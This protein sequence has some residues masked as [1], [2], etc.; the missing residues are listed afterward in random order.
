MLE[1]KT[2]YSQG[3]CLRYAL[4]MSPRTAHSI[5]AGLVALCFSASL[6]AQ[7]FETL[8]MEGLTAY[9]EGDYEDA[10]E[11]FE[12]AYVLNP[13]PVLLYNIARSY[14]KQGNDACVSALDYYQHFID[15]PHPD[16]NQIEK[17]KLHLAELY[18]CGPLPAFHGVVS[19]LQGDPV[20]VVISDGCAP[21]EEDGWRCLGAGP[22]VF[23]LRNADGSRS[24]Q[25][26]EISEL[27]HV[28]RIHTHNDRLLLTWS[29]KKSQGEALLLMD[30][31]ALHLADRGAR[32]ERVQN[33]LGCSERL[34]CETPSLEVETLPTEFVRSCQVSSCG[35]DFVRSERMVLDRD[36]VR[37]VSHAAEDDHLPGPMWEGHDTQGHPL[38][39][40]LL[41]RCWSE[42]LAGQRQPITCLHLPLRIQVEL[43]NGDTPVHTLEPLSLWQDDLRGLD[44]LPVHLS[45][46][47]PFARAPELLELR[48]GQGNMAWLTA[49][50][51]GLHPVLTLEPE[52]GT[53]LE[54]GVEGCEQSLSCQLSPLGDVRWPELEV[55]CEAQ[56]CAGVQR[57]ERNLAWV[58]QRYER[59]FHVGDSDP[60]VMSATGEEVRVHLSSGLLGCL[61]SRPEDLCE[62]LWVELWPDGTQAVYEIPLE[63]GYALKTVEVAP[64]APGEPP[65]L[66]LLLE[67][68]EDDDVYHSLERSSRWYAPMRGE[69]PALWMEFRPE[70]RFSETVHGDLDLD[71]PLGS[72]VRGET[73]CTHEVLPHAKAL[74][75]G[76]VVERCRTVSQDNCEGTSGASTLERLYQST[77]EGYT[78]HPELQAV[79]LEAVDESILSPAVFELL[80]QHCKDHEIPD[81]MAATT[82]FTVSLD[83]RG[84]Q[85]RA[86]RIQIARELSLILLLNADGEVLFANA[87]HRFELLSTHHQG[88]FDIRGRINTMPECYQDTLFVWQKGGYNVGE[89]RSEVCR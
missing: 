57:W 75:W 20:G 25:S 84:T 41:S 87:Q 22:I 68:R 79:P 56:S 6:E 26:L 18:G 50:S 15:S 31:D 72:E 1:R 5:I 48:T 38:S 3:A 39:Y 9:Q 40:T 24:T 45:T 34:T 44:A 59:V 10:V 65:L 74:R 78:S 76:P 37:F 8:V 33:G 81:C 32:V 16:P 54:P 21:V 47:A 61:D 23:E 64:L 52:R 63:L 82:T 53:T 30:T 36:A 12:A 71:C 70:Y 66:H 46:S 7:D 62:P 55:R 19:D 13:D 88:Y 27:G 83:T 43:P 60:R 69:A 42:A 86:F 49:D 80:L 17:A 14:H 67:L 85:A 35:T 2:S 11:S 73:L 51:D 4:A 77:S 58:D 29:Q 89:R 28:E